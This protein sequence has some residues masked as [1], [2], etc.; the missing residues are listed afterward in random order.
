MTFGRVPLT[1]V[2]IDVDVCTLAYGAAPCTAALG[3]TG[4]R[5]CHN[6]FATCQDQDNFDAGT[7]TLRFCYNQ[8][9]IPKVA[10]IYPALMSVST[11]AAEINLS[12]IDPRST[13]LGR[14]ARVEVMLQDFVDD[15]A[16]T[17]PYQA[18]RASGAAQDDAIGYDPSRGTFFAKLLARSPYYVGRALRVKR[19]YFGDDLATMPTAHYVISEWRGPNAGGAVQVTAKDVLDLVDTDKAV[20]PKPSTGKLAAAIAAGAASLTLTPAGVGDAEYPASGRACIGKEVMTFTRSGD[21]LTLTARGVDGTTAAA[22]SALDVV[23]VCLRYDGNRACD[24]INDLLTV[25]G[26]V[27]SAF[28]TLADWIAEEDSW[29]GGTQFSAT[30]TRP[31]GIALLIG[32]LCQHGLMI[33]WDEVAQQVRYRV[34]RPIAPGET[35]HKLDDTANF[36]EGSLDLEY[37]DNQRASAVYFWHGMIDPTDS[38]E[39][40]RNFS[41]LA[42]ALDVSSA[43][44]T[45]YG[46]DRIKAIYSRWFGETGNNAFAAIIAE[47]LVSR[48]RDTPRVITGLVDVKDAGLEPAQIVDLQTYLAQDVTGDASPLRA[49]IRSIERRE[50][51]LHF[52]A[53]SY[54]LIGRFGFWMDGDVDELDYDDATD[55]ERAEGAYWM[56]DDIGDFGDGTGPYVYF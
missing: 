50:D 29:L 35:I 51:R 9:G 54:S 43:S 44:S 8:G 42:V 46:E 20:A 33:W 14:R 40:G 7:L 2:E 11:R 6:T 24:L 27:P 17:D 32:E 38:A 23:Q 10:G 36:I 37:A 39:D 30:I 21:V 16:Y 28:V 49:Q 26:P 56:D 53:E 55:E 1:I 45:E 4:V 13:A 3:T 52:A 5:K 18:E 41:K 12:G 25:Q 48:Y 31:T 19:G 15:D 22:H 47:R 34:N